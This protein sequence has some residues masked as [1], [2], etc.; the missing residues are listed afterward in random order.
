MDPDTY[1]NIFDIVWID[2]DVQNVDCY[3]M[4]KFILNNPQDGYVRIVKEYMPTIIK[5]SFINNKGQTVNNPY[6]NGIPVNLKTDL[7][8]VSEGKRKGRNYIN[9]ELY[10]KDHFLFWIYLK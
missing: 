3:F 9:E 8:V 7:F 4:S 5:V 1:K 2:D 10:C 6:K